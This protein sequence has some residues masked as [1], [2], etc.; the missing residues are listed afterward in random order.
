MTGSQIPGRPS[1]GSWLTYG[2]G[3]ESEDLPAFVVAT[4]TD[5]GKTCGR[6]LTITIGVVDFYLVNTKE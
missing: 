3:S 2:L 1:M 6:S 4:S 5:K